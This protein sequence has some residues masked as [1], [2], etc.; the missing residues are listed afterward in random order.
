MSVLNV[1]M[2]GSPKNTQTHM[3]TS[4]WVSGLFEECPLGLQSCWLIPLW[5]GEQTFAP[6]GFTSLAH[7]RTAMIGKFIRFLL[8]TR[9]IWTG[10][11]W[12]GWEWGGGGGG[13]RL[14]E[15]RGC[16]TA[17][18]VITR[19]TFRI[20]MRSLK[21]FDFITNCI[22]GADYSAACGVTQRLY[23]IISCTC[24]VKLYTNHL[25]VYWS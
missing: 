2:S 10:V 15:P 3:H 21:W 23:N 4:A 24:Y 7:L 11:V 25:S 14:S 12:R 18:P 13:G 9:S 22:S 17:L 6:H 19:S 8:I 20:M 16:W 1:K 5:K